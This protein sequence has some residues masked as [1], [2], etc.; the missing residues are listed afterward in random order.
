MIFIVLFQISQ[1]IYMGCLRGAG[2]TTYTAA[3]ST[4]SVTI[5][6]T[7]V[8]YL[9]GFVLGWGMVGIWL[10]IV[11]DQL[12]RFMFGSIRFAMGK[13]TKITI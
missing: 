12:S 1:V 10:G 8:S 2:D 4:I 9:C 11:A 3:A 7:G 5:I 13:W 6:R